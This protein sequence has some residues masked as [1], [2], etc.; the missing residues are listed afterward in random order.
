MK[1][2]LMSIVLLL[3]VIP[4][5]ACGNKNG[6][7][8]VEETP[9]TVA[10]I[11]EK[12]FKEIAKEEKDVETIAN[13]LSSNEVVKTK[14]VVEKLNRDSYIEGFDIE[15]KEF[16]S[17]AVFRP[18]ISSIPFIGYI[19]EVENPEEFSKQLS[20]NANLNWNICTSAD[21]MKVSIVD[22]YVFFVMSPKTFE[23]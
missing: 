7:T 4:L 6:E 3:G 21:E 13:K 14:L 8:K 20:D 12:E 17:G 10:G 19:F 23:E 22:N 18:M 1:R 16:K 2:I 5:C 11:L 9:K 15:I